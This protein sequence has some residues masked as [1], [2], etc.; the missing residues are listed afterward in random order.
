M[1]SKKVFVRAINKMKELE[2]LCDKLSKL[3]VNIDDITCEVQTLLLEILETSSDLQLEDWGTDISW[4]CFDCNFGTENNVIT[5]NT[6]EQITIDSPE[7]LYDYLAAGGNS[8]FASL[9]VHHPNIPVIFDFD[10]VLFEAKWEK[11]CI[12]TPFLSNEEINQLAKTHPER[13]YTTVIPRMQILVQEISNHPLYALSHM[14]S[15]EEKAIKQKMIK[16]YYGDTIP[17]DNVIRA[18]S[19]MDKIKYLEELYNKYGEFIYV[20]DT[21]P[22]LEEFEDHFAERL[23]KCHF[24]HISSMFV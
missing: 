4:Y 22:Y 24:F 5:Y 23:E 20:D 1:L 15:E 9:L 14:N 16:S 17:K 6:G 18:L 11:D 7:K 8:V 10:G 12:R 19:A 2:E 13:F 21:L 3:G